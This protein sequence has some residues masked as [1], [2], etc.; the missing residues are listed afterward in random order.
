ML[1]CKL[2]CRKGKQD[3]WV[4]GWSGAASISSRGTGTPNFWP[5]GTCARVIISLRPRHPD[6]YRNHRYHHITNI[7]PI[8]AAC[9]KG[10]SLAPF[11]SLSSVTPSPSPSPPSKRVCGLIFKNSRGFPLPLSVTFY[12]VGFYHLSPLSFRRGGR[13]GEAEDK[14]HAPCCVFVRRL[15]TRR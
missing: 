13:G 9:A 14:L 3:A 6:K 2:N 1:A 12:Q 15:R 10:V 11:P 8:L 5:M 7:F 4:V